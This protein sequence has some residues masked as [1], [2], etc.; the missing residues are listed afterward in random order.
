MAINS[1]IPSIY[2]QQQQL[3]SSIPSVPQMGGGLLSSI[4]SAPQMQSSQLGLA[5][6]LANSKSASLE[7]KIWAQNYLSNYYKNNP[8]AG[9]G[10]LSVL[11][12]NNAQ[13]PAQ[14]Q[15]SGNSGFTVIGQTTFSD[16][17]RAANNAF[18]PA[19][20]AALGPGQRNSGG[21][22]GA[23]SAGASTSGKPGGGL[24]NNLPSGALTGGATQMPAVTSSYAGGNLNYAQPGMPSAQPGAPAGPLVMQQGNPQA[25]LDAY[26]QT[27]GYQ[28][29]NTPGAYEASPGYQYAVD[30][31]MSQVQRNAA[32]R[33]LLDSGAVLKGMQDRAQGMALQ[34]YGNWWNRQ[35]QQFT[36]YQN[37]LAG[38][39]GG[40]VGGDMAYNL[41]QAQA[42]G[43]MQTGS[44]LGSLFSGQGAAGYGGLVNT[45]AAQSGNINTA[46][47]QQ[48]QVNSAN[49]GT[50]LAGAVYNRGLF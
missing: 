46:G 49:Q 22:G 37:R 18:N 45:G 28:L 36:D 4:P 9:G 27:A 43:T 10:T 47:A 6:Q 12:S 50:M 40:N 19:F 30:Q 34:D 15:P 24:L 26:R 44:N 1:Y 38:L 21:G 5:Q 48:A 14:P 39:A 17:L 11:P 32:S 20:G 3:Q 16:D 29:L 2:P 8:G 25:G 7:N 31:A 41:G 13:P 33:G 35:N 42:G 23:A